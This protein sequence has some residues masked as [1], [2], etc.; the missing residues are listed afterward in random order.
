[1][2]PPICRARS[3]PGETVIK[4]GPDTSALLSVAIT[5]GI[6]VALIGPVVDFFSKVPFGDFFATEGKLSQSSRW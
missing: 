6:I 4:I 5:V 3:R 2:P 1:M